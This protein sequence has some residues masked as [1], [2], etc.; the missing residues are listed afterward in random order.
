MANVWE[1]AMT[2]L[3]GDLKSS[4]RYLITTVHETPLHGAFECA[5]DSW[6]VIHNNKS[7][8]KIHFL[9]LPA[10]FWIPIIFSNLSF[11][12]SDLLYISEKP[13]GTS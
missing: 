5:N 1:K 9:T 11:N 13:S 8:E 6:L 4:L 7:G 3:A 10:C 2:I 12:C